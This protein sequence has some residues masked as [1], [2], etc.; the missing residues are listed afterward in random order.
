MPI[1]KLRLKMMMMF[2]RTTSRIIQKF[3]PSLLEKLQIE[4]S[5]YGSHAMSVLYSACLR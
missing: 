3:Y 2:L 4:A 5:G 1:E